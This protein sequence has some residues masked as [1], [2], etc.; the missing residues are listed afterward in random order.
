MTDTEK[1]LCDLLDEV[2]LNPVKVMDPEW[3]ERALKAIDEASKEK[4]IPW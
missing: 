3:T 4:E 1:K 2:I